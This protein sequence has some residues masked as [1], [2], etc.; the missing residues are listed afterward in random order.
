MNSYL[1]S[2]EVVD[3]KHPA[4]LAEAR[5]LSAGAADSVE[6][7]RRC[8]VWVRDYIQHSRDFR[9]D[10]VSCSASEVLVTGTGW[11]YAKSHL[12]GALLR[13]NG[14]PAGFC[15]QRLSKGDGSRPPYTLHGLNAVHLPG[16]GWY[17]IDARGNKPGVDAQFSPPAERLAFLPQSGAERD[18]PEIL[19]KPLPLVVA[20]LRAN[21]SCDG[22]Y[23]NLPDWELPSL[24]AALG[25]AR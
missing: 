2:T 9:R 19:P 10:E 24:S 23:D 15:Y 5:R 1:Q 8:F 17:R 21:C 20:A 18:F 4:V 16:F 13:A 7:A 11:C 6:I 14:I 25:A 3:W 12:L 22:M